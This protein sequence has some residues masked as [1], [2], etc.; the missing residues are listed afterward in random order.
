MK[1]SCIKKYGSYS[2]NTVARF[3]AHGVHAVIHFLSQSTTTV[4]LLYHVH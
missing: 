2:K 4:F 3:M 1:K